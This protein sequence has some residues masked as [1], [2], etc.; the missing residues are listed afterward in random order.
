MKNYNYLKV[1]RFL[2]RL[3]KSENPLCIGGRLCTV[4]SN[5]FVIGE[6]GSENCLST[7]IG[8]G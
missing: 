2:I 4:W 6:F 5:D 8:F 3:P 7:N 1:T